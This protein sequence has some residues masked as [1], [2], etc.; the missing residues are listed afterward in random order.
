MKNHTTIII[1]ALLLGGCHGG[2]IP[3]QESA[4]VRVQVQSV[5]PV[6]SQD[7]NYY[8]GTVEEGYS[9]SLGF[10]AGGRVAAV[11]VHEGQ[12][13]RQGQLLAELDSTIAVSTWRAAHSA[14]ERAEDGYRRSKIVY[15]QGGLPE[16]KWVE[17][18]SQLDQARAMADLARHNLDNCRLKAPSAGTVGARLVEAGSVVAPGQPVLRIVGTDR[19][20][21]KLSIPEVDISHISVGQR[22]LVDVL[23]DES[24]TYSGRVEE[25]A[26]EADMLSHTY[27]VR[28]N[29]GSGSG[30]LLPGMVC[31]V[32]FAEGSASLGCEI[33]R[34]AVQLDPDGSRYVWVVTDSATVC[35]RMITIG[36]VTP[37][38]VIV[39]SGLHQGE[40]VV[41]DGAQKLSEGSKVTIAGQ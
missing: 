40:I 5:E 9:A 7:G 20:Y 21:V 25:R 11:Y 38:G 18:S 4:P 31:R 37:G 22:A 13:V 1:A 10:E 6:V 28:V 19:L 2:T 16:V 26:I 24:R 30:K 34:R 3:S 29:I 33:P 17:V 14:L 41:T 27:K 12:A 8:V 15:D 32:R 35:R 36:D 39:D 23:A